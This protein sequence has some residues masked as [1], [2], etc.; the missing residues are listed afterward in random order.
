MK[1]ITS[2]IVLF[3]SISLA[4]AQSS[5]AT[6]V[7]VLLNSTTTAPAFTSE[8]GTAPSQLCG[9]TGGVG[10]KGKWYTYTALQNNTVII[11]T[12]LPQNNN[13]DTRVIVYSGTC[14]GLVCVGSN[15]DYNG[16]NSSYLIFAVTAGTTYTIAFDNKYSQAGFDFTLMVAPPPIPFLLL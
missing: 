8:N 15:D 14:A 6:P 3:F 2:S 12:L 1:K 16:T 5:C 7:S 11:S 9:L 10:T 13:A 4:V